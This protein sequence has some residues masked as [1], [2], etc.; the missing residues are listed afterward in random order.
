MSLLS[1]QIIIAFL[2]LGFENSFLNGF[3]LPQHFYTK[4]F[5]YFLGNSYKFGRSHLPYLESHNVVN[6]ELLGILNERSHNKIKDTLAIPDKYGLQ[7]KISSGL[8]AVLPLGN[9]VFERLKRIIRVEMAKLNAVELTFPIL[10]PELILEDKLKSFGS[11]LFSLKDRDKQKYYLSPSC[12]DLSCIL[13]KK[14][15]F[16][17]SKS[18]LPIILYQINAKFRDELRVSESF[19]R[20]KEFLMFDAYSFHSNKNCSSVYYTLFLESFKNML[21]LMKLKYR[22]EERSEDGVESHELRVVLGGPN[23]ENDTDSDTLE[24]AHLFKFDTSYSQKNDLRYETTDR[25]REDVYMNSYGIGLNRLLTALVKNFSNEVGLKFPQVV[26]PYDL[27]IISCNQETDELSSLLK[28]GL[29]RKGLSVLLDDRDE[30][31]KKKVLDSKRIGIPHMILLSPKFQRMKPN[32]IHM[33]LWEEINKNSRISNYYNLNQSPES[34][35]YKKDTV[36]LSNYMDTAVEYHPIL[37]ENS[38]IIKLRDLLKL[39]N[40]S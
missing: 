21:D 16:P 5:P 15:N 18:Y 4:N 2:F 25:L 34:L 8:Y 20:S 7:S 33:E 26:A 22:V 36:N 1:F 19:C 13:I 3:I 29:I 37:S 38:Y 17:L 31:I 11:E 40:V 14:E 10:Q 39:L 28:R 24:V 32:K 35:I 12:E 30:T 23:S 6:S 27:T 9:R